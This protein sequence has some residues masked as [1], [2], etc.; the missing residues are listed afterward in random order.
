MNNELYKILLLLI[1]IM[2]YDDFPACC[3]GILTCDLKFQGESVVLIQQYKLS[4]LSDETLKT[5]V[6]CTGSYPQACK[7][8]QTGFRKSR[9]LPR[10]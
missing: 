2:M 7:R 1:V 6:P 10:L 8:S 9:G 5:E 3:R 4:D